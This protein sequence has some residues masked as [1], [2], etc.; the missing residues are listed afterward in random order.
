MEDEKS[1]YYIMNVCVYDKTNAEPTE[2]SE[3]WFILRRI[4]TF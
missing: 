1:F 2:F 4:L 3:V